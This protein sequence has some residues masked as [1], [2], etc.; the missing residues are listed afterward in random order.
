MEEKVTL[1]TLAKGA[2]AELF[3]KE[4]QKVIGNIS[5]VNTEATAPREVILRVLITP[6]K[7]R[8]VGAT[9]V[10]VS[11]K[12][13]SFVPAETVIYMGKK[14]GEYIAVENDPKQ[15]SLLKADEPV[16]LSAVPSGKD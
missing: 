6:N 5:D 12:L 8:N 7:D 1:H 14:G 11:S 13:A 4:L 3:E 16:R 10:R 15:M 2:A 9:E